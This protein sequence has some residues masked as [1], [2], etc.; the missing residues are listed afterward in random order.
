M[1]ERLEHPIFFRDEKHDW[2]ASPPSE[3]N[4]VIMRYLLAMSHFTDWEPEERGVY[5]DIGS[6]DGFGTEMLGS[7]FQK[8]YG[9]ERRDECRDH[10]TRFHSRAGTEYFHSLDIVDPDRRIDFVTMLEVIEHMSPERGETLI[11]SLAS[12]MSPHGILFLTTPHAKTQSGENP[13][14]HYHVHEYRPSEMKA[15][16]GKYFNKVEV[17]NFTGFQF[18]A[19]AGEPKH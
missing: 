10:A 1:S 13:I 15:L 5:V 19:I 9:I 8:S 6:G 2:D 4:Q 3:K 12:W 18:Q 17:L 14:N 16:L 7:C 11:K